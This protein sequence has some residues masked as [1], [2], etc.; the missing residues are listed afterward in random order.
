[1]RHQVE[2]MDD[3][4]SHQAAKTI[5]MFNPVSIMSEQD[6]DKDTGKYKL[7]ISI[8]FENYHMSRAQIH[9]NNGAT[10]L[11]FPQEARLRNFTYS[12]AVT[13]DIHIK[14]I[15]RQGTNLDNF[16]TYHKI[17]PKIHIGKIP[18]MLNSN[19]CILKQYKHVD[20][21][22]TGECRFD[23]GG[24][25]II[26][27]SE[28]TILCQERAAEN[29]IQVFNISKNN[30][31][32]TWSAEMKSV[33]DF[34]CISPKQINMMV[35]AKNNGFGFGVYVQVPRMKTPVPLFVIFR[36]LNV[37]SDKDI[38]KHILLDT[39]DKANKKI[40]YALQGSIIDANNI[41]TNEE[42]IKTLMNQA[43]FTPIN[44]DKEQG[45]KRKREFTMD[46]IN[47]DLFPHCQSP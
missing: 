19:I 26:N 39:N 16:H 7:E 14:Y 31:K 24:Y 41:L 30:T 10:K 13:V 4:Y 21:D 25:F 9:E 6:L 37:M 18:I 3:F 46:V 32:W 42:A 34:K 40:L 29:R 2:S 33:P 5:D 15:V 23:A 35:S 22:I 20:V 12:S 27:G 44:M 28:K 43:L 1:M 47:I 11:M 36:A 8:S 38:C 17:L 45:L